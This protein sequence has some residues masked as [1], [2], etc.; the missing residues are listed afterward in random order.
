MTRV[1]LASWLA[2]FALALA[3]TAF[4][5]LLSWD[6]FYESETVR[7]DGVVFSHDEGSLI[8]RNGT[9]VI[10]LLLIPIAITAMCFAVSFRRTR[11]SRIWMWTFSLLLLGLSGSLG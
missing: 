2:G 10:W 9:W 1:S 6:G 7:S 4:A 11:W 3:L 5:F 8:E